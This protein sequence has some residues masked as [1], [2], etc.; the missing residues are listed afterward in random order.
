MPGA[1]DL[2]ALAAGGAITAMENV[3]DGNVRNAYALCRC[4]GMLMYQV[5]AQGSTSGIC[6]RTS[7]SGLSG[8]Q[9]SCVHTCLRALSAAATTLRR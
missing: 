5:A 4:V 7:V 6:V 9:L 1:Y 8:M 2:A 3:L